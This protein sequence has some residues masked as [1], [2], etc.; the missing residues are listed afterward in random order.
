MPFSVQNKAGYGVFISDAAVKK[1]WDGTEYLSCPCQSTS[2][3]LFDQKELMF[4][5]R[6]TPVFSS[7][8]YLSCRYSSKFAMNACA[9]SHDCWLKI[10]Q[11][12]T[13]D[14]DWVWRDRS[15]DFVMLVLNAKKIDILAGGVHLWAAWQPARINLSVEWA[16]S[17]ICA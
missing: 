12:W 17:D 15:S 5:I 14:R 6:P 7:L 3:N 4:M 2:S 16:I 1:S 9:S 10:T 8:V 11:V 13:R